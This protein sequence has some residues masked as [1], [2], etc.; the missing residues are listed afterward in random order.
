MEQQIKF[1]VDG[2]KFT[3]LDGEIFG[4]GGNSISEI[5]AAVKFLLQ[6]QAAK[7]VQTISGLTVARGW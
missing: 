5:Q 1:N 3:V 6:D 7:S 4:I 2:T